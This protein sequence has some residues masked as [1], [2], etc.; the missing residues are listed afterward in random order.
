MIQRAVEGLVLEL[1][2]QRAHRQAHGDVRVGALEIG[3]PGNQPGGR[4]RGHDRDMDAAA[5]AG[6]TDQAKSVL[7]DLIQMVTDPP[8]VLGAVFGQRNAASHPGEQLHAQPRLQAGDL[9]VDG[10][11]GQDSSSAARE[12]LPSRA[13]ASKACSALRL[14]MLLMADGTPNGRPRRAGDQ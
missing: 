3:Q 5:H 10:A 11:M 6:A 9:P 14:G 8:S 13:D 4:Q 12:K 7:L 2:G 1:E